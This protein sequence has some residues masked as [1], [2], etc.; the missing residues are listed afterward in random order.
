[1][2]KPILAFWSLVVLSLLTSAVAY[3]ATLKPFTAHYDLSRS[4]IEFGAVR[5]AF[6]RTK[7]GRFLYESE[8]NPKGIGKLLRKDRIVERSIWR[9]Q[10]NRILPLDY[11]YIHEGSRK[12]RNVSLKFEWDKGRVVN[13]AEGHSWTMDIP[14]GTLDKFVTQLAVMLDLQ[15]GKENLRYAV[16]DGGH[17]KHYEYTEDGRERVETQLGPFDTVRLLRGKV[18]KTAKTT[19]WCAPALDYLPVRVERRNEEGVYRMEIG[20]LEGLKE[21]AVRVGP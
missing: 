19:L 12:D 11:T 8:T 9:L 17:L 2:T 10:D 13:T 6:E 4:G 3:S 21:I 1:M 20:A 16:A 5:L 18:G 7:D 14:P 15:A